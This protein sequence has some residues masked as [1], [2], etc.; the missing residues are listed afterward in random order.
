MKVVQRKNR[1][2]RGDTS[3]H[4][5]RATSWS[6]VGTWALAL[7]VATGLWL[8]VNMG[9][10]TSERTLRVRLEPENVPVGMVII[11]PV[12]EYAEVRVSGSGL[13]L[14]SIDQKNLRTALD[15]SGTKPG[16]LTFS[17]DSKNFELPRKVEVTRIT[18]SQITFHLDTLT[19]RQVSV[20]LERMG[21]VPAGLRLKELT[22][23]PEKVEVSG[24]KSRVDMLQSLFT[25]PLDLSRLQP[26]TQQVDVS[27]TQPGGLVQL[28]MP[29]IRVRTVVEPVVV[30]R[31][32]RKVKVEV[33]DAGRPLRARPDSITLV[34]RGP[35]RELSSL[36][37]SVGAAFVDASQMEGPPPYR[38]KP[39]ARLP[40]GL[41][42]LRTEPAEVVLEPAGDEGPPP[43]RT[44][45]TEK[46]T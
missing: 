38:V 24:P 35:E 19:K 15:L 37:L 18:P 11:N 22:L 45:D 28:K 39:Q 8:L 44:K 40:E 25:A 10:R 5:L 27:L 46:K 21:E 13:I 23:V 14:S 4:R 7:V 20:R 3:W 32:I 34:V 26:G 9:E 1:V 30:E 12:P 41:E 36:E 42:L 17:L 33:R 43:N 16:V 31:E 6:D 29:E 2:R